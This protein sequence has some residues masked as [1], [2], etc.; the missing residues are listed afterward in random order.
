M[1]CNGQSSGGVLQSALAGNQKVGG[2]ELRNVSCFCC[3]TFA[4][5]RPP[6]QCGAGLDPN[7]RHDIILNV[8]LHVLIDLAKSNSSITGALLFFAQI[9]K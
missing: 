8:F 9:I 4:I 7:K 2:A 1:K 6:M 3:F 5:M